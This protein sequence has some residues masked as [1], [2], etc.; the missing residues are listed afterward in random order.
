M[1]AE[2]EIEGGSLAKALGYVNQVRARAANSFLKRA[3]GSNAANYVI[4]QYASFPDQAYARSAVRFERQLELHSE[5]HR[6]YDLVRWG[7]AATTLNKFIAYE[8]PK[9]G[10]GALNGASFDAGV[11]ELLP[12]PQSQIDLLG[13]DILKQNPGY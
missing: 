13:S 2:C 7:I 5:G 4:S 8:A 6:F 9:Y 11:D 1:A 12:I 3:D 10:L